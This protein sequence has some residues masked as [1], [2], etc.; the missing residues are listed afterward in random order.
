MRW[1]TSGIN[2]NRAINVFPC[3]TGRG[4]DNY[5]KRSAS[6][7][8]RTSMALVISVIASSPEGQR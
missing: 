6:G 8:R 5:D 1:R 7:L 3:D 2:T 4:T